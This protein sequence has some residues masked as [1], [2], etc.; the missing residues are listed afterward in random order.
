MYF[1]DHP[2]RH[3]HAR[4]G[5]DEATIVIATGDVLA[6][7]IPARALRLVREWLTVHRAELDANW[8][9]ARNHDKPEPVRPLP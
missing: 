9:R 3:F 8:D 4:Y 6:G 7:G 2:P 1:A 5:G